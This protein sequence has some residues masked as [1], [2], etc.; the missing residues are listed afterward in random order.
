MMFGRAF[1]AYVWQSLANANSDDSD[2]C[3]S[4]QSDIEAHEY[5]P[6]S[7]GTLS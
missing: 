4:S 6:S 5:G 3:G 7:G 1:D 2:L